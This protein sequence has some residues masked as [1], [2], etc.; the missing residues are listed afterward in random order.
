[1]PPQVSEVRVIVLSD[2]CCTRGSFVIQ[3]CYNTWSDLRG[4]GPCGWDTHRKQTVINKRVYMLSFEDEV[5]YFINNETYFNS[6]NAVPPDGYILLYDVTSRESFAFIER[7]VGVIVEGIRGGSLIARG[8]ERNSDRERDSIAKNGNRRVDAGSDSLVRMGSKDK[9][10]HA[11]S[12][13]LFKTSVLPWTRKDRSG[14]QSGIPACTF[15]CFPRFPMELQLA[16]LRACLTSTTPVIE[17]APHLAGINIAVLRVNR[18]FHT[19]GTKIYQTQNYFLPRRPIYLVGDI[20]WVGIQGRSR[21]VSMD[22]GIELAD[23]HGCIH[24]DSSSRKLEPVQRV[25]DGLVRDVLSRRQGQGV[26]GDLPGSTPREK[27]LRSVAQRV[28]R[29]FD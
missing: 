24:F 12:G 6:R 2:S 15:T 1:M 20:S 25:V 8:G 28:S 5:P 4:Y 18:F 29:L 13:G 19:E 26:E 16:I 21:V 14:K 9:V 22:E 7:A 23:R 17:D 10:Q 3:Y 27:S 11:A